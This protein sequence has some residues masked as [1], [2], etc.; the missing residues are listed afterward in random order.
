MSG[1][2]SSRGSFDE[3]EDEDEEEEGS[4]VARSVEDMRAGGSTFAIFTTVEGELGAGGEDEVLVMRRALLSLPLLLPPP[5]TLVAAAASSACFLPLVRI[6][7][8]LFFFSPL[9]VW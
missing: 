3:G 6:M 5:S 1:N 9:I 4:R 7:A 8:F 2:W